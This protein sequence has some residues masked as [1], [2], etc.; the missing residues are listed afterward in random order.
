[1]Q[2]PF[3]RRRRRLHGR[4]CG[5]TESNQTKRR[6]VIPPVFVGCRHRRRRRRRRRCVVGGGMNQHET[7]RNETSRNATQRNATQRNATK[8]NETSLHSS[9][10]HSVVVVPRTNKERWKSVITH[11]LC[12]YNTKAPSFLHH[13]MDDVVTTRDARFGEIV[14]SFVCSF[15]V[16]LLCRRRRRRR[17]RRS[18][19]LPL[20]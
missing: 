10:R 4:R 9:A 5:E 15:V 6:S 17:R 7:K 16:R 20:P 3:R 8:R 13:G 18:F 11:I 2:C 1:M 14:R 19:A 12:I